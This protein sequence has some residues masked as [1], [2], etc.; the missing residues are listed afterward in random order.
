MDSGPNAPPGNAVVPATASDDESDY[1]EAGQDAP[2]WEDS[3]DER[4]VVSL[5]SVPRLRKLRK[6][7]G[8][9]LINGKEYA[10]R[11][12]R[13]FERLHPTPEWA[14]KGGAT[15]KPSKKRRRIS[16][17]GESSAEE[18]SSDE[19]MDVDK[20][21][22]STQ[23]LAQ[24]LK[25]AD[26]LTRGHEKGVAKKRKLRPE[27]LDIQRTKDISG[28]Q[29]VCPPKFP[30][31]SN[32]NIFTVRNH[33]PLLPPNVPAPPVLRPQ[34]H[35]VPPPHP[36]HASQP[37]PAPHVSPHQADTAHDD[38]LPPIPFRCAHLPQRAP[39]LLPHLEPQQRHH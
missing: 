27:V 33:V 14:Q 1:A 23:P 20:D 3:D 13:Q 25:D 29:P 15:R 19:D 18:T 26:G 34:L 24:L 17:A 21:D 31:T 12:R 2:A 10:R 16:Q 28:T 36:T 32:S 35:A 7:E 30:L 9:D 6:N 37:Q 11:L 39:P 38:R 5:A 22:I 4:M 8:E